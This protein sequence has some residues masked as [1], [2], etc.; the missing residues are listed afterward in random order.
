MELSTCFASP[1]IYYSLACF[2]YILSGVFGAIIR[3]RHMCHPY[4]EQGDY[5]YPARRQVTFF[6]GAVV[7][8]FPYVLCPS[9]PDAWFSHEVSESSFTLSALQFCSSDIF[10]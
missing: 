3:W 6:Y 8:Q 7:L 9:D 2:T 4:S 1:E 10:E 5:F